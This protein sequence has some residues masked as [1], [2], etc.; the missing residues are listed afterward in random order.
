MHYVYIL[1]S[2]PTGRYYVGST[3]DVERRLV[4]HNAGNSRSTKGYVPWKVVHIE[5]YE[6]KSEALCRENE[7]KR[8]KSRSFIESLIP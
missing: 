4:K 3:S 6:T 7:I 5:E 1:E 8:H 2:I